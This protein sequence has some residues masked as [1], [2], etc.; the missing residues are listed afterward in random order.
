[1]K[2]PAEQG[3]VGEYKAV[4]TQTGD[5]DA[6][7]VCGND[8]RCIRGRSAD[9]VVLC[10]SGDLDAPIVTLRAINALTAAK[11]GVLIP[12]QC[13]YLALEGLGHL[14]KT[15]YMVRDNLNPG[16]T[17]AG[18]VLTMYDARTN[19]SNALSHLR[20]ALNDRTQPVPF[21]HVE[22]QTIQWNSES[23]TWVDANA[24]AEH[25]A[26]AQ[27][28]DAVDVYRG[29]FLEGFSL[30]D[31]PAFEQWALVLRE[32]LQRQPG[33]PVPA[34]DP[35]RSADPAQVVPDWGLARNA[36]IDMHRRSQR[37]L[38]PVT[39]ELP[40]IGEPSAAD[41]IVEVSLISDALA[42]LS[43]H[44][45]AVILEAFVHGRDTNEIAARIGIPPGTVKSR[46]YYG[47]RS[48]RAALEEREVLT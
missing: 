26:R 18:V 11:D 37:R 3:G 35:R 2:N 29:S 14:L 40:D 44:H 36:A 30:P 31:S 7:F 16:L 41:R 10:A 13:E 32:R 27:W 19:L 9:G 20:T 22:R 34:A 33:S 5:F 6:D 47:M 8:V 21:L 12:V 1:M 15:V 38:R 43:D 17:I 4:G 48:L 42:D 28:A 24:F 39:D 46:M 25:I 23:D 45:R